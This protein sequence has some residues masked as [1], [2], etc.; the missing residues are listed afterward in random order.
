MKSSLVKFCCWG[1]GG[2]GVHSE[3]PALEG[4]VLIH[5][6][7]GVTVHHSPSLGKSGLELEAGIAEARIL[8]ELCLLAHF[9]S[10]AQRSYTAQ[11]SLPRDGAAHSGLVLLTSVI[12]QDNTHS[13]R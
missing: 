6:N 5:S 3:Q 7:F 9:L 8:E 13:D 12:N 4:K 2:E 1:P 11:A 10:H